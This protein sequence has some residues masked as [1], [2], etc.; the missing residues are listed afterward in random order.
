MKAN[1]TQQK[2]LTDLRRQLHQRPEP[3]WCEF[4]T[5]SLVV[6][7]LDDSGVDDVF[8]GSEAL[9]VEARLGVPSREQL[10]DW[11]ERARRNGAREDVLEQTEGGN[12]GVVA[13]VR[14]GDGPTVGVRVDIDGLRVE[15]SA[16]ETHR[17]TADGFRSKHGGC[18]HACGH[19]ANTAMGIGLLDAIRDSEFKGTL[20]LFFQPAS[21]I[22]GGGKPMAKTAHLDDVEHFIVLNTGMGYETGELVAG[23]DDMY[24]IERLRAEFIGESSHAGQTPNAGRNAIQAMSTAT[25]QL[26]AVPR[27]ADGATRV[28]VGIVEAGSATNVIAERAVLKADIRGETSDILEFVRDRTDRVF[29]GAAQMHDCAVDVETIGQAPSSDSDEELVTLFADVFEAHPSVTSTREHEP[30]GTGED[31]AWFMNAVRER[32]G[33]ATHVVV[34]SD[35]AGGHHTSTFDID[36]RSLSIGVDTLLAAIESLE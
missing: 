22:E 17:P 19:D 16:A 28:N 1:Q 25:A 30:F 18:M 4:Y 29:S 12:T 21:E 26:Y 6:D 7:A 31:A 23:I 8:I 14:C 35:L 13:T 24:A 20:K 11:H 10:R 2:H 15:E 9:D 36:E 5:T 34:G 33:N 3:P 27:H 32:G